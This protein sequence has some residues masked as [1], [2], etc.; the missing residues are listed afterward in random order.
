MNY[1]HILRRLYSDLARVYY[2]EGDINTTKFNALKHSMENSDLNLCHTEY[3]D[4][5]NLL[6]K[7]HYMHYDIIF[8]LGFYGKLIHDCDAEYGNN[9]VIV[10]IL[11]KAIQEYDN[12]ETNF[13]TYGDKAWITISIRK[14]ELK[15]LC[16]NIQLIK[17][18]NELYELR[19]GF[20]SNNNNLHLAY[21]DCVLCKAIFLEYYMNNLE[22]EAKNTFD[23]CKKLLKES[24]AIYEEFGNKYGQYRINFILLFLEFFMDLSKDPIQAEDNFRDKLKTMINPKYNR[25]FEMIKNILSKKTIKPE[26]IL[27]FFSYYPI[28]LQ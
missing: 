13:K 15:L 21:I 8:Q 24:K 11:E 17:V 19:D 10:D 22:S 6:T 2:L 5:Y 25:E 9:P 12:C 20:I 4:F 18:L 26:I 27:R 28:I 23:N 14:N 1:Y 7:A 16:S 3:E